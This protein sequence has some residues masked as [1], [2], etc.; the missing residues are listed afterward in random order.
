MLNEVC[1]DDVPD[2]AQGC[3]ATLQLVIAGED[4]LLKV[5]QINADIGNAFESDVGE[6]SAIDGRHLS[7]AG[8]VWSR[9]AGDDAHLIERLSETL[10]DETVMKAG[11]VE[12]APK[13]SNA[14][15][16]PLRLH[17]VGVT[18]NENLRGC[19]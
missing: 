5:E 2:F 1:A 19:G 3:V 7:D 4:F 11:R 12:A 18:T 15:W 6:G 9:A 8:F 14:L 13:Q 16:H 17:A 10:G